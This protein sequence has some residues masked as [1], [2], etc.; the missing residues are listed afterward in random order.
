MRRNRRVCEVVCVAVGNNETTDFRRPS[1]V[2][3]RTR[4]RTETARGGRRL[5]G[6]PD[7]VTVRVALNDSRPSKI[8]KST[9]ENRR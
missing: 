4:T 5:H 8:T 1:G 3:E 2:R 7:R 9:R 6:S